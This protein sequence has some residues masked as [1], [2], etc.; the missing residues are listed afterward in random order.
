[1]EFVSSWGCGIVVFVIKCGTE[2]FGLV[3][4]LGVSL[5]F[6]WGRLGYGGLGS[7]TLAQVIEF[8]GHSFVLGGKS[9]EV[10]L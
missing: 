9:G 6:S 1:M 3:P 10:A 4:E 8:V 5:E 7:D 2:G